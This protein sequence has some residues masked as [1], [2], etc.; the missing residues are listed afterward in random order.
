[1]NTRD[2]QRSVEFYGAVFGWEAHLVAAGEGEGNATP[3]NYTEFHLA[4]RRFAGMLPMVGDSWPADMPNQWMVYF[5]VED[6]EAAVAKVEALGGTVMMPPTVIPAWDV[7][8]GQG[9][10]RCSVQRHSI[11]GAP[12]R[13]LIAPSQ[14]DT[15]GSAKTLNTSESRADEFSTMIR[16]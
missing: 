6:C 16:R 3:A 14:C 13:R 10:A 12:D 7:R 1:M 9:S 11:G 15:S 8:R 5:A 2:P 4:D